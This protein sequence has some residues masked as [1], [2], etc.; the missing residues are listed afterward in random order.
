MCAQITE[1]TASERQLARIG[2]AGWLALGCRREFKL[3]L[4]LTRFCELC[5]CVCVLAKSE[6]VVCAAATF[7]KA[8]ARIIAHAFIVQGSCSSG[9]AERANRLAAW[10]C[11]KIN[12]D[13]STFGPR[14]TPHNSSLFHIEQLANQPILAITRPLANPAPRTQIEVPLRPQ[15]RCA[16]SL[17]GE[18]FSELEVLIRDNGQSRRGMEHTK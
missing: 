18:E 12:N 1:T 9:R 7:V 15:L 6:G 8:S 2:F 3:L 4:M 5:V 13:G 10:R 11:S 17:G 14:P 16:L